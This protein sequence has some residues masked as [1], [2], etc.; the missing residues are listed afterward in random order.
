MS[1]VETT[2][3][4]D[5]S[6]RAN[7]AVAAPA[8]YQTGDRDFFVAINHYRLF[9]KSLSHDD[10]I[11]LHCEDERQA[12]NLSIGRHRRSATVNDG[13]LPTRW[14]GLL[15]N[16]QKVFK[17]RDP[18]FVSGDENW[19]RDECKS[20]EERRK[21]KKSA[22]HESHHTVLGL[23]ATLYSRSNHGLGYINA[24]RTSA[25]R[26]RIR[27]IVRTGIESS[28]FL[29]HHRMLSGEE[30]VFIDI[31]LDPE[32]MAV[33]HQQLLARPAASLGVSFHFDHL[34]HGGW[35]FAKDY[36]VFYVKRTCELPIT[37]VSFDIT[38]G[39]WGSFNP[40]AQTSRFW[41]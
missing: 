24:E 13:Y 26:E 9:S 19:W 17:R 29:A 21:S 38:D 25:H 40:G 6:R 36:D 5:R 37:N 15:S 11:K 27:F 2:I 8:G 32:R 33:L 20:L 10:Y 1:F 35:P 4:V 7:I 3:P 14:N 31:K 28:S 18:H 16:Y 12:D 41:S 30:R 39:G 22:V 23:M 34:H